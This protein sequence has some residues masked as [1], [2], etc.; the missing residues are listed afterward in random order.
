VSKTADFLQSVWSD[1]WFLA[2]PADAKL[3]YVWGF[4]NEHGNMAGLFTVGRPLAEME[5][6]LR[7]AQ[8]DGA[9]EAVHPKLLFDEPTGAW[10]VV[11][12]AK[13]VRAKT[14]QI[15]KS[16]ARAVKECPHPDFR[17]R[18]LEKYGSHAWLKSSLAEVQVNLTAIRSVEPLRP[19]LVEV[20]S[21]SRSRSGS[22]EGTTDQDYARA[23]IRDGLEP[24]LVR[25]VVDA[26]LIAPRVE[27]DPQ[28]DTTI[29]SGISAFLADF[30]P[31]DTRRHALAAARTG[32]E[33]A[34]NPNFRTTSAGQLF[35]HAL[36]HHR[37]KGWPSPSRNRFAR[38]ED[39]TDRRLAEAEL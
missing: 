1:P 20:P 16:V 9:L 33:W 7:G 22:K 6:G 5:T 28:H 3:L 23:Q 2:L 38:G 24:G 12:R 17:A 35:L 26:L 13:H 18:F 36:R 31:A 25:D 29:L 30:A 21:Q 15:A 39:D 11:G 19:N 10:W 34:L 4:T 32:A 8:M 37:D 14:V 27:L